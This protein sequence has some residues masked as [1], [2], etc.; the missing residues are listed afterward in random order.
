M[1]VFESVE[2]FHYPLERVYGWHTRPGALTRLS[3]EWAQTVLKESYPPLQPGSRAEL[4]TSVPGTTGVV[5]VPFIVEHAQGPTPHSFM[6]CMVKGPLAHWE[7]THTFS[8]PAGTSPGENAGQACIIHDRIQ[9]EVLPSALRSAGKAGSK[10]SVA[11]TRKAME[12]TL[13]KTFVDR[14]RRLR[15]DLAFHSELEQRYGHSRLKVLI[16]GASGMIGSHVAALLSTG[17]HQVRTLVRGDLQRDDQIQWGPDQGAVDTNALAWADVVIHLGGRS[18]ATR[19]TESHKHEIMRSR[20]QSTRTLVDACAA[21]E[22]SERPR[23]FI[24]ASA[25][26]AYGSQRGDDV[27]TESSALGSGFL[28]DV[29]QQWEQAAMRVEELGM[30]WVS[31]RTGVVL[32]SL[33]GV[34]N[35]QI[36]LYASGL[37]G[38]L[39]GGRQWLSW[40][41]LDDIASMYVWAALDESLTG[42]V[43]GVSV[44]PVRHKDFSVALGKAL[45]RPA[46]LPTPSFAPSMVLGRQGAQELALAS[47]YVLPNALEQA[48]FPFRHKSLEQALS[49]TLPSASR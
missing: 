12:S 30:R 33:G 45:K 4:K 40:V 49:W 48:G 6:D 46:V 32:S 43:N 28:A 10:F 37:G 11:F 26:G 35:L 20:V 17:G 31:L 7:H 9:Y 16:A 47:Q 21:L 42:P 23:A 14:G 1:V 25:I 36:P 41:S 5:R 44:D 34:L 29:C 8:D 3:P 27:L 39:G 22:V 2:R 24:C 13:E 18:I 38:P 19:F 15:A